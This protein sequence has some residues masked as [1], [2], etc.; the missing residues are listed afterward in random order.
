MSVFS[1][2]IESILKSFGKEAGKASKEAGQNASKNASPKSSKATHATPHTTQAQ[3]S[4]TNNA[5][6]PNQNPQRQDMQNAIKGDGFSTKQNPTPP[7]TDYTTKITL[8]SWVR[9]VA[10]LHPSKEVEADLQKLYEKHPKMFSKPSEVYKLIQEVKQNPQFFYTNNQPNIALIGKMLDNGK[11]G[12]IGIQKDY[13][14]DKIRVQH[15][16][17]ASNANKDNQRLQKRSNDYPL[18]ERTTSTQ[19]HSAQEREGNRPNGANTLSKDNQK[20]FSINQ[21]KN[22]QNHAKAQEKTPFMR[23]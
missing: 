13:A 23:D 10:G 20:D 8:E 15:A 12:K 18:V 11:L 21:T 14:G 5:I 1:K 3:K 22:E 6:M 4:T 9:E 19:P 7:K 17:K 2:A 16:T